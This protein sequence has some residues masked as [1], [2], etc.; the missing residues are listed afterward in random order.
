MTQRR[1]DGR[2]AAPISLRLTPDHA[3]ISVGDDVY[4]VFRRVRNPSR[5]SRRWQSRAAFQARTNTFASCQLPALFSERRH[6]IM[7]WNLDVPAR[8]LGRIADIGRRYRS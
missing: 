5:G 4:G 2:M 1:V 7:G 6:G 3:T 8:L